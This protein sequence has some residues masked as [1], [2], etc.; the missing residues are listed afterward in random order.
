MLTISF[1]LSGFTSYFKVQKPEKADWEDDLI[2]KSEL[3]ADD[4]VWD[5]TS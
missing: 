5:Q 1:Q 2:T 3:T 4:P